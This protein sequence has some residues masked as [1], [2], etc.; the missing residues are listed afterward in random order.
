VR[1]GYRYGYN[2]QEKCPEI[3]EGHTTALYW[4]YDGRLGRRWNLDP[5]PN[6]SI[7]QYA[8]FENNPIWFS[9]VLGD[10][11]RIYNTNGN[12]LHTI[13]DSR[14]NQE[15]FFK[16]GQYE[17]HYEFYNKYVNIDGKYNENIDFQAGYFRKASMHF[18]GTNTR[19]GLKELAAAGEKERNEQY[20]VL[21]IS[22]SRELEVINKSNIIPIAKVYGSNNAGQNIQPDGTRSP[23]G[24]ALSDGFAS[25]FLS[26]NSNIA[27]D[28][29]THGIYSLK[30]RGGGSNLLN[31]S[32]ED[33]KGSTLQNKSEKMGQPFGYSIIATTKGYTIYTIVPNA[34]Y[35]ERSF[36]FKGKYIG[37]SIQK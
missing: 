23:V 35:E 21:T 28:A 5:K 19:V 17:R 11:T 18:I 20:A 14:G 34:T 26:E 4:E 33:E 15:H 2:G 3:A 22:S 10:T 1:R 9:D 29:H 30:F 6:P 12:L 13:N 25:R 32:G 27:T 24:V 8:T 7:S 36:N 37:T 16:P 31:A